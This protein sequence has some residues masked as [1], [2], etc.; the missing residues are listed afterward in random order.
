MPKTAAV[1]RHVMFEDLGLFAAPLVAAGYTVQYRDAGVYGLAE[2]FA[3]DLLVLCG[4]PIGVYQ[5]ADYPWLGEEK[6]L[7][8]TRLA[9]RRPTLGLCLGAQLIAAALGARVYAGPVKEI[10]WGTLTLSVDGAASCLA[11]L[12]DVPVLHWH[13]DT[14]DLPAEATLLA[15]SPLYPHQAFAVGGNVLGLQFHA[16]ADPARI[17]QWLV[18]HCA[19]LAAAGISVP[20]LRAR[21]AEVAAQVRAAAP[22]VLGGWLAQLS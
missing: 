16:E 20:A 2:A 13:G 11:P 18:G 22:A 7:L 15:S 8:A 1:I 6:R 14:F 12:Y 4:G 3:A 9:Q 5:E 17:E 21:T 10:G 19:E